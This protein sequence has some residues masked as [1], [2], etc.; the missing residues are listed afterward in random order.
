MDLLRYRLMPLAALIFFVTGIQP[1]Y[2][3]DTGWQL[4]I[5][6]ED[7]A[8]NSSNIVIGTSDEGTDG[9]DS[10][11]DQ[12]A[13]PAPP[14]GSYDLRIVDDNDD[15]F[16]QIGPLT[17]VSSTWSISTRPSDDD[18]F[19]TL[20]WDTSVLTEAE[21]V[22]E[23]E[24]STESETQVIDMRE[25]GSAELPTGEQSVTINH[26][27]QQSVTETYSEGW[28]LIGYP[29]E[30]SGAD[31]YTVFP[32]AIPGT[33]FT[34]QGSYSEPE[35]LEPGIGYWIRLSEEETVDLEPPFFS[36]VSLSFEP[37]WYIISGPGVELPVSSVFNADGA[38]FVE[39]SLK[40]F[41]L[42]NGYEDADTLRPGRGYWVRSNGTFSIEINGNSTSSQ[43]KQPV[44]Q[45]AGP[46][47]FSE[48]TVQNDSNNPLTFFLGESLEDESVNP[49][50]FSM[51]PIPPNGAFD[52]RF[53]N[54]SRIATNGAGTLA[55]QSPGESMVLTYPGNN[56]EIPLE[57]EITR[58][59]VE[60]NQLVVLAPGGEQ[61]VDGSD[62]TEI[63]VSLGVVS[64]NE[65]ENERPNRLELAQNY[66]N[67]FNPVTVIGYSL[68]RSSEVS[69]EIYDMTGRRVAV[70]NEGVQN[71]GRHSVEF[72]ASD[73]SSG[74][75][76]YRLH[77][78][79]NVLTRKMTLVK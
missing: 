56:S 69:I 7:P 24:Y 34:H 42:E 71:A 39:G 10:A 70:L 31:P 8:G 36:G 62:I 32:S 29:A 14:N 67:P 66:P 47:N 5:A 35:S 20:S 28:Q 41:S 53:T 68:P 58:K 6:G 16:R 18:E 76:M 13:P 22:F 15:Y 65:T 30:S 9:Y 38:D 2:A 77:S 63:D 57:F 60:D 52:I 45:L 61:T 17:I 55:V 46:E 23:L 73:L 26:V 37:G 64:S 50:S 49:L 3:Q 11:L 75:Y 12:F 43:S 25:S 59:G 21:G 74:I 72:D 33:F 78:S 54:D 1:L 51:P 4:E 19:V 79:G 48:F 27:V 44:K 40:K